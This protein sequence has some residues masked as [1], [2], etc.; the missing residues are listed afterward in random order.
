MVVV[1]DLPVDLVVA[2]D[3]T[4]GVYQVVDRDDAV[5]SPGIASSPGGLRLS[6]LL[7]DR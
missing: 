7:P 1:A 3:L 4:Q 5:S 6:L 2:R